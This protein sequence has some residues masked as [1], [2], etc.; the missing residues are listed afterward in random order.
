MTKTAWEV[1]LVDGY[2]GR[3]GGLDEAS[4]CG[5]VKLEGTP[6]VEKTTSGTGASQR[7][8]YTNSDPP[9]L[10]EVGRWQQY[11]VEVKETN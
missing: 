2:I 3:V 10:S 6:L 8:C 5:R 1:G 9:S 4:R 7:L 11:S